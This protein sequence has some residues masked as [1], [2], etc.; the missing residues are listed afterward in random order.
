MTAKKRSNVNSLLSQ[1]NAKRAIAQISMKPVTSPDDHSP[2][3]CHSWLIFGS[4][5][6]TPSQ[7]Y[8]V[9]ITAV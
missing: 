4:A 2:M 5:R 8:N 7:Y 1:D 9:A 3:D 6:A